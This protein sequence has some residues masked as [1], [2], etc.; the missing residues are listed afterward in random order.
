VRVLLVDDSSRI[1]AMIRSLLRHDIPDLEEVYEC[2]SSEQALAL[3]ANVAPDWVLMDIKLPGMN[4]LEGTRRLTSEHPDANVVIVT[5]Y[6]DP[7][8]RD[9]ARKVGASGYVLKDRLE[10]LAVLLRAGV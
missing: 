5:Q 3:Y 10:E 1:R 7:A 8:Y 6:D 9:E 2:D 4:G